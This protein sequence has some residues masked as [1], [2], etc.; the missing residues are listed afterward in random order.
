MQTLGYA[1]QMERAG[2]T[3]NTGEAYKGHFLNFKK[4]TAALNP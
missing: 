1:V 2:L 3:Q 4:A